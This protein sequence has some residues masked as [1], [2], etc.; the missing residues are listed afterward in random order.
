MKFKIN[1][2]AFIGGVGILFLLNDLVGMIQ[3]QAWVDALINLELIL[4]M[5]YYIFIYPTKP[6][7]MN[8]VLMAFIAFHFTVVGIEAILQQNFLNMVVSGVVLVFVVGYSW[9]DRKNKYRL[10]LNLKPKKRQ[11]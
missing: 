1:W 8:R 11:G 10:K 3:A 7:N 4:L 6:L 9:Y 5:A 2:I